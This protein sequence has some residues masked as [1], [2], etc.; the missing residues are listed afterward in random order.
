MR[1]G[2]TGVLLGLISLLAAMAIVLNEIVG[3]G[4]VRFGQRQA[5]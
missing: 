2:M 5:E 3:R 1:L 4:E